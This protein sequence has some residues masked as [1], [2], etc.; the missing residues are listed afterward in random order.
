MA[1]LLHILA[2]PRADGVS[3]T[4]KVA[5]AFFDAYRQAQPNATID[6][7]DL[8]AASLPAM[9]A[10]GVEAKLKHQAAEELQGAVAQ[11]W[12]E[13]ER[14]V[15]QFLA[16]D[17]YVFTAPMW[18]FG[19]PYRLKHYFDVIVQAGL[20]FRFVSGSVEG[21]AAGRPAALLTSR[22]ADYRPGSPFAPF[23]QQ[24]P[25]LKAILGFLGITDFRVAAFEGTD[26]HGAEERLAL[27]VEQARAL[28]RSF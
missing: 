18:N 11:R 5:T 4:R 15:Q 19:I 28:A 6:T 20:T 2:A 9:D 22:G 21:L 17:K 26:S 10:L 14:F 13:I 27:A 8:F 23:N 12:A 1:K 16:A 7:L 25:Y 3:R 24:E